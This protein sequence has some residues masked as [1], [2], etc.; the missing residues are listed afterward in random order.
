MN[1]KS[2]KHNT[3][4]E[5]FTQDLKH[6]LLILPVLKKHAIK[7]IVL[8]GSAKLKEQVKQAQAHVVE[9]RGDPNSV[10]YL[11]ITEN[12]FAGFTVE[13]IVGDWKNI[14]IREDYYYFLNPPQSFTQ[15]EFSKIK[16]IFAGVDYHLNGVDLEGINPRSATGKANKSGK[17]RFANSKSLDTRRKRE[18]QRRLA[19]WM[20]AVALGEKQAD[21]ADLLNTSVRTVKS[22]CKSIKNPIRIIDLF[23]GL[24]G[25]NLGFQALH[26]PMSVEFASDIDK[27]VQ[28]VY[29]RIYQHEVFGDINAIDARDIPD[30][31]ILCGGFPC[32]PFS[33]AGLQQGLNH[34]GKGDLIFS[35]F[36]I[37]KAKQPE[38]FLLENVRRLETNENGKTFKSIVK[39]LEGC[40]Y[41]VKTKVLFTDDFGLPQARARLYFV[42]FRNDIEGASSFEFPKPF[43]F[44]QPLDDLLQHH[45]AVPDHT[46]HSLDILKKIEPGIGKVGRIKQ[47]K[48]DGVTVN[49]SNTAYTLMTNNSPYQNSV[50]GIRVLSPKEQV[51]LQGFEPARMLEIFEELKLAPSVIARLCGNSVSVPVITSIAGEMLKVLRKQ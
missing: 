27:T 46:F 10:D 21:I 34:V 39:G 26:Y 49:A 18:K 45:D 12:L 29:K 37:L 50:D 4:C 32:Q 14:D 38:A 11:K 5:P 35:I 24:G 48:R 42:G 2:W 36:G 15:T 30:H 3:Y 33:G 16:A 47:I 22:D 1:I 13:V 9:E 7:R 25:F 19:V 40:G 6:V 8:N 17:R 43:D 51:Q 41:I 44:H 20:A 28:R 23:C 31:D